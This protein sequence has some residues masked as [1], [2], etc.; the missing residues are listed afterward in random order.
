MS[1]LINATCYCVFCQLTKLKEKLTKEDAARKEMENAQTE[2][3][4]EK[5]QLFMQ[6]QRVQQIITF[7]YTCVNTFE[8]IRNKKRLLMQK[9]WL[10][11]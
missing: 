8:F 6:L 1:D 5:Q 9:K 3:M 11:S 2:L 10:K 7:N 4:Q